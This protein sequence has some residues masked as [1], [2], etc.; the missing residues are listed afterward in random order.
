MKI[1]DK[2]W[3]PSE[4]T[5]PV[6][7]ELLKSQPIQRLKYISHYGPPKEFYSVPGFSRYDH[8]VGVMI[9]LRKLG[10]S[11]EEQVA[12]LVHDAS[13]TVFSHIIDFVFSTSSQDNYQ[14]DRHR[15]VIENSEIPQ[16]LEKHEIDLEPVITLDGFSLLESPTPTVCADRLDYSMREF[17]HW[18]APDSIEPI[19]NGLTTNEGRIVFSNFESA[20]LFGKQYMKL[21]R[22]HWAGGEAVIRYHLFAKIL[23]EA[24]DNQILNLADL[25][26]TDEEA[27]SKMRQSGNKNIL[28]IMEKLRQESVRD[29]MVQPNTF[30]AIQRIKKFRYVDPQ[31]Y[32]GNTKNLVNLT[33]V[34][35]EYC[36][37][38]KEVREHTAR[39]I[40]LRP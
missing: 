13:H 15:Q 12:G 35:K 11:L 7:I 14:D 9:I 31:F 36:E 6:L 32:C 4:I 21:Q 10:A 26:G 16:I 24:F 22:E 37:M 20:S 29:E 33:E 23:K 5:D 30:G 25:D 8:S 40:W 38:L 19:K 28:D 2:V 1:D 39:G 34:D 3:G 18:S 17:A 27:I